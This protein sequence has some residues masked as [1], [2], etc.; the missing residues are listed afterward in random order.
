MEAKLLKNSIFLIICLAL[1]IEPFHQPKQRAKRFPDESDEAERQ[2]KTNLNIYPI[3]LPPNHDL[4]FDIRPR[5]C[6]CPWIGMKS[7]RRAEL[8]AEN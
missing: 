7:S 3:C 5:P 8:M 4:K 1:T 2:K 6:E